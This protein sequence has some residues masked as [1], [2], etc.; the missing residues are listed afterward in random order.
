MCWGAV[1]TYLCRHGV[2][3]LLH[4]GAEIH[5]LEGRRPVRIS[6]ELLHQHEVQEHSLLNFRVSHLLQH[7]EHVQHVHSQ[8][9]MLYVP[10]V[11]SR[12]YS[13]TSRNVLDRL[14]QNTKRSITASSRR[15]KAG[16]ITGGL[17]YT[18]YQVLFA[19]R[20]TS[21]RSST[22]TSFGVPMSMA[23]TYRAI[24]MLVSVRCGTAVAAYALPH[25]P[26]SCKMTPSSTDSRR[27]CRPEHPL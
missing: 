26:R 22:A 24:C 5:P 27:D 10:H 6:R 16:E 13:I 14:D 20:L 19:F 25:E 2:R 21:T 23:T 12:G 17:L 15:R 7:V 1:N 3:E 18:R 8:R 11:V 9:S 4:A